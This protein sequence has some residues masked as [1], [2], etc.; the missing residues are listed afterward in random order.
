MSL[1]QIDPIGWLSDSLKQQI[2]DSVVSFVAEQAEKVLGDE[3]VQTL[4]RLRSDEPFWTLAKSSVLTGDGIAPRRQVTRTLDDIRTTVAVTLER[5]DIT[6]ARSDDQVTLVSRALT[7]QRTLLV[8]DDLE[9]VDDEWVNVFLRELPPPTKAI[10]TTRHRIDVAYPVRL[11]GMP[12]K[13]GLAL[14]AQE[15]VKR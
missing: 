3:A 9:T 1:I 6:H 14:M 4:R 2:I 12:K 15:C 13:D 5:E 7:Q 8:V 10:V 11:T